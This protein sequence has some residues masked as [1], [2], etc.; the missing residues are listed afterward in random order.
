MFD[1]S[2]FLAFTDV[3]GNEEH[4]VRT[5]RTLS[6][7]QDRA[8]LQARGFDSADRLRAR[9]DIEQLRSDRQNIRDLLPQDRI[10]GS[11]TPLRVAAKY[12]ALLAR[13]DQLD[14]IER[15]WLDQ[16]VLDDQADQA[17]LEGEGGRVLHEGT[18]VRVPEPFVHH[19]PPFPR[20]I[21]AQ[22]VLDNRDDAPARRDV[23]PARPDS[24]GLRAERAHAALEQTDALLRQ[25]TSHGQPSTRLLPPLPS[26]ASVFGLRDVSVLATPTTSRRGL[27]TPT[28]RTARPLGLLQPTS[29]D[30]HP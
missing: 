25:A 23:I 24:R 17:E 21:L 9:A 28:S 7:P 3:L 8:F 20:P 14:D 2:S 1:T 6:P 19:S 5:A 15:V 22:G 11:A 10:G 18:H 4:Y 29:K 27:Y 16:A 13:Y 26:L 30:E 12:R